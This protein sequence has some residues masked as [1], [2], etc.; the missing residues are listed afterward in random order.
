MDIHTHH[1]EEHKKKTGICGG[2]SDKKDSSCDREVQSLLERHQVEILSK[3]GV[4]SDD[5]H[6]HTKL[7]VKSFTT[8]VVA[9]TNYTIYFEFNKV[10]H[11]AVIF[12]GLPA[13]GNQESVTSVA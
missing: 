13:N 7:I 11:H 1:E 12:K 9:G 5:K 2:H 8:Q 10:E 3:L 6:G 4:Q